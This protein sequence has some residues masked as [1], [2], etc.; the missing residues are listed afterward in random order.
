[1]HISFIPVKNYVRA[2]LP[3]ARWRIDYSRLL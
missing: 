1:V 3:R 2:P